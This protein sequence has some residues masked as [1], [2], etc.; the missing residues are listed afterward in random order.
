MT[1][2][3][4]NL[5]KSDLDLIADFSL[6]L[7]R[8]EQSLNKAFFEREFLARQLILALLTRHHLLIWGEPGTAKS[9]MVLAAFGAITGVG[10]DGKPAQVFS[11]QIDSNTRE[12]ELIGPID[13]PAL[14]KGSMQRN[15]EGHLPTA[16]FAF[17]DE[18]FDGPGLGRGLNDILHERRLIA[19]RQQLPVPL[20]TAVGATNRSPE[21]VL[22]ILQMLQLNAFLDRFLFVGKVKRL[23]ES[24]S[25]QAML[26]NHVSNGKHPVISPLKFAD[27][28]RVSNLIQETNQYSDEDPILY[29]YFE[30]M[31]K[32]MLQMGQEKVSDRRLAWKTQIVEAEALRNG[33]V[34]LIP[35]DVLAV[36]YSVGYEAD[37]P[38]VALFLQIAK[39]MVAKL[40]AQLDQAVDKGL[41]VQLDRIKDRMAAVKNSMATVDDA[42]VG[43]NLR[44]LNNLRKELADMNPQQDATRQKILKMQK[45]AEKLLETLTRPR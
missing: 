39:P 9:A 20:M 28:M 44:E 43:A 27:L 32:F 37:S 26:R 15:V 30:V 24:A 31:R 21:E 22:E 14:E 42:Q 29:L 17:L 35:E 12:E 8:Y 1:L 10:Q 5:T 19:G 18:L 36:A 25:I 45:D 2:S 13:I 7:A 16:H 4:D 6:Q 33:R 3:I 40:Q 23:Q 41:L 11:I 34:R 38:E